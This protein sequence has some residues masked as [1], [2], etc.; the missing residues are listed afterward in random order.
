ME[1]R[2][3][4]VAQS[5]AVDAR[6]NSISAFNIMEEIHAATYPIVV[7]TMA[8]LAMIDQGESEPDRP[9]VQLQ[10]SLG[11]QQLFQ[12]PFQV[13]FQ[14]RRKGKALAEF[15]GLV[16]PAP[17]V[18]RLSLSYNGQPFAAWEIVCDQ[19]LPPQLQMLLANQQ[20]APQH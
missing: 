20:A 10:I 13:D 8:I 18:L 12:G 17:G 3:F 7:P 16:V 19:A 2:L 9:D 15:N 14:G 6:T 4:L 1:A 11:G 5:S